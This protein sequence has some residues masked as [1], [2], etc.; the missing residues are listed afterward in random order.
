MAM[1]NAWEWPT[2]YGACDV[3]GML[4]GKAHFI[5]ELPDHRYL[6]CPS[7]NNL[8]CFEPKART[9]VSLMDKIAKLHEYRYFVGACP[10]TDRH[11]AV[12]TQNGAFLI[13]TKTWSVAAFPCENVI[14][15]YSSKYNCM[16]RTE[17]GIVYV[18]TQNGL[19]ALE[20]KKGGKG[21]ECRRVEGMANDCIRSLVCDA[22]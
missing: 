15:E 11:T 18:G 6:V 8:G 5:A 9:Y 20:P 19:F 4:A 2:L 21:Y 12:Y 13:D 7:L 16:M 1:K 10:L 14:G 3:K 22:F 17:D